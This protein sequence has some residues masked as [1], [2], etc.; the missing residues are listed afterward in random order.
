MYLAA[1]LND[2]PLADPA[3]LQP[4]SLA[5]A[6]DLAKEALETAPYGRAL[7]G[8]HAAAAAHLARCE[9]HML[10]PPPADPY[11]ATV[12]EMRSA[13]AC[14]AQSLAV[15]LLDGGHAHA[16]MR[17]ALLEAAALL[18]ANRELGG[19]NEILQVRRP[20]WTVRWQSD[21]ASRPTPAAHLGLM[22]HTTYKRFPYICTV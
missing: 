16:G 12:P 18:L 6:R 3:A 2:G 8:L 14:L 4:I 20:H 21:A 7:P 5:A 10:L 19:A 13:R 11:K 9:R 22:G 17:T 1:H 15:G